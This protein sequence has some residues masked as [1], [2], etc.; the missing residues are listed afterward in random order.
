[1][2]QS[3]IQKK[4]NQLR[5]LKSCSKYSDEQLWEKAASSLKKKEKFT[6]YTFQGL[7]YPDSKSKKEAEKK[8][9]DISSQYNVTDL[10]DLQ[11]LEERVYLAYLCDLYKERNAKAIDM[12]G[13]SDKIS[14]FEA[15][16]IK[17]D[18][19]YQDT[20]SKITELDDRLGIGKKEEKQGFDAYREFYVRALQDAEDNIG[21]HVVRCDECGNWIHLLY[22]VKDYKAFPYAMLRNT[23]L[24]N[25]PLMELIDKKVLTMEQVAKIWYQPTTDY[26]KICYEEIYL[27]DKNAREREV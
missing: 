21:D 5:S 26:V 24:Y 23:W 6:G 17:D 1:M 25:E 14:F 8:F 27:K 2:N 20:I 18:K 11:L 12:L 7:G 4:F 16:N 10:K 15:I 9:Q 3:A 13:K 22:E 19:W